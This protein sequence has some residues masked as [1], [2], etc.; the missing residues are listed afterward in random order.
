[1]SIITAEYLFTKA[2][3]VT[4]MLDC[5]RQRADRKHPFDDLTNLLQGKYLTWKR[6]FSLS[7]QREEDGS[8]KVWQRQWQIFPNRS[9]DS[10]HCKTKPQIWVSHKSVIISFNTAQQNIMHYGSVVLSKYYATCCWSI[11]YSC[12]RN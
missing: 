7:I 10:A 3:P 9:S 6:P 1:M 5:N 8:F 11:R 2:P 12:T 4:I